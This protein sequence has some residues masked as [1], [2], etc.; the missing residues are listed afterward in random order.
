MTMHNSTGLSFL[1]CYTKIT[2][3][4]VV[5]GSTASLG[6]CSARN[7]Y[8]KTEFDDLLDSNAK[9]IHV[10]SSVATKAKSLNFTTQQK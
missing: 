7:I 6:H 8:T 1:L 2:Q 9:T 5:Q 4:L 3:Y 10:D